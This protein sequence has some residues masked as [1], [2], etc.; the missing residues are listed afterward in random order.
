MDLVEVAVYLPAEDAAEAYR[1]AANV[2]GRPFGPNRNA[3]AFVAARGR[4][5][6]L[7][8]PSRDRPGNGSGGVIDRPFCCAVAE[9]C[10]S[11]GSCYDD[12]TVRC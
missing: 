4:C 9:A 1:A 12:G 5:A 8:V 10:V 3:S 11:T 7:V 2:L 6:G